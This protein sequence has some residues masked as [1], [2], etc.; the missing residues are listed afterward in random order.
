MGV[1]VLIEHFMTSWYKT[2]I[3]ILI[4]F[5]SAYLWC[6][7][8]GQGIFGSVDWLVGFKKKMENWKSWFDVKCLFHG[9]CIVGVYKLKIKYFRMELE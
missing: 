7:A 5:N 3:M 4:I 1:C 6:A 9:K 2:F 8:D